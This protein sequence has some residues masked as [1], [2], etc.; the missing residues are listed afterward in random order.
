MFDSL[1]VLDHVRL[2]FSQGSLL[3]LNIA[4]AIIMFGVALSIKFNE[5][6]EVVKKP[7][8]T[9]I[10]YISQFFVLPAITFLLV[11]IIRPTPSVAL[12]MILVASCP[13]GNIS[14]FL[15]SLANG[16][17]ALSVTMTALATLSAI[18]MTP[19][20]FS[21]WGEMYVNFYNKRGGEFLRPLEIE[22]L[23]MFITVFI[24]L[25]IPVILGLLFNNYL[26]RIALKVKKPLQRFSIL[27][28]L[29]MVFVMLK[30]NFEQFTVSIHLIFI[31]VLLHNALALGSGFG[32][33]SIFK[34]KRKDRRSISI[35][36]G[37][38]NSGLALTLMFNP[39]IFPPD[40]ELGGMAV[41]AGWWGIWHII[42]GL[43]MASLWGRKPLNKVVT[44]K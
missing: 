16:N 5:F 41:I 37:I 38:Q 3:F 25:G 18:F 36:T 33:A 19:F 10:G 24:I 28:F 17:S 6:K 34:L 20:N 35:E 12:G 44:K 26:P 40:F 23:Q 8:P 30:N 22:P 32:L 27:F 7:R 13:G 9:I 21:F 15:S 29:I 42:S 39:K 14:N 2:N 1:E 43:I 4:L 11:M 31:I